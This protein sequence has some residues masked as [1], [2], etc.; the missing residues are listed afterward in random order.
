M[1]PEGLDQFVPL[2]STLQQSWGKA[3]KYLFIA[4]HLKE[5]ISLFDI[6][7]LMLALIY[8]WDIAFDIS[9]P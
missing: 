3:F 9:F 2:S 5:F 4:E 7:L 8:H 1:Q 6:S